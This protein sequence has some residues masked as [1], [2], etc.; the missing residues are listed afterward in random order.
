MK[1]NGEIVWTIYY[2]AADCH[3]VAIV[4]FRTPENFLGAKLA[5][6]NSLRPELPVITPFLFF[7][8]DIHFLILLK[9]DLCAREGEK[10]NSQF[11]KAPGKI[12]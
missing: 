7:Y 11:L 10:L 12:R 2:K 1:S 5:R 9:V 4:K 6:R 8:F 3:N